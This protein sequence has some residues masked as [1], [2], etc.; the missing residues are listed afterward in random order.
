MVKLLTL[1]SGRLGT[2]ME[3]VA[4]T[5]L[6]GVMVLIGSDIVGRLFGCPVPGTYEIVSLAGGLI[7]GLALP[8]TSRA[9]GHVATDILLARLP[10]KSRLF[11][12]VTTRLIG[13]ILFLLA[14]YG[15]VSMGVR[16]KESGEVTAELSL[17]FY[18]VVYAIGGAFFVQT[19]IL[20]SE[21]IE[22]IKSRKDTGIP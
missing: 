5:A 20:L 1:Y 4:G 10:E 16:F 15:M 6:I 19:L 7:I 12:T 22:R 11:L 18:Y 17:S 3:I 2:W 13:I 14:A 21:I 9:K 8:A